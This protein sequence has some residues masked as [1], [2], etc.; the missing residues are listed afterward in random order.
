MKICRRS[1]TIASSRDGDKR[2]W[3]LPARKRSR[4]IRRQNIRGRRRIAL[5]MSVTAEANHFRARGLE[6]ANAY[7][8]RRQMARIGF[9]SCAGRPSIHKCRD[10][11]AQKYPRDVER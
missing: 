9:D 7:H 6:I 2:R 10:I 11:W 5:L 1:N 4:P 3:A 8:R